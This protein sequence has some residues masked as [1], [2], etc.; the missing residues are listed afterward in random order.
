MIWIFYGI[1][2]MITAFMLMIVFVKDRVKSYEDDL[3]NPNLHN[4]D[5]I[6]AASSMLGGTIWPISLFIIIGYL[7][8]RAA[9]KI[10][11]DKSKN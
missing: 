4:D 6:M 11:L 5:Y 7:F 2:S 9:Y 1:M 8:I 10:V 3:R